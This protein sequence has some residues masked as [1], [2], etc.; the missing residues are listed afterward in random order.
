ML[1]EQTTL[2]ALARIKQGR[3][4]DLS[5]VI[6]TGAPRIPP[7]QTPYLI[8]SGATS[9]N[10]IRH[11]AKLGATNEAGSNLERIELT[12]HVG[13]HIDALGHFTI[14][15]RMF[16]AG[17]AD[18]LV[19]DYGLER[20]GVEHIP[21][22]I[23]RGVCIDVSTLDGGDLLESG[24]VVT[25]GE[26]QAWCERTGTDIQKGDAVFINTGW[27][28]FFMSDNDKYVAGEPG[29]DVEAAR[30]LTGQD[31]VVIGADNMAVEVLPSA[32]HPNSIMPVH[33]H[34]LV[35]A[36]V[37]LIENIVLDELVAEGILTFCFIVLPVKF[38]GATG[39]PVRPIAVL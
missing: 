11:R 19:G 17:S 4:I 35:E 10:T 6:E 33:Q 30:W 25:A 28:R 20:L 39:S 23:T 24:R 7:N 9:R 32:D 27:G 12:T 26:L 15:D 13:T 14:G 38:K 21:P 5:H 31:V 22:I 1:N 34:C 37:N 2:A 8:T 3:I 18:E 36:G 16:D 29:L